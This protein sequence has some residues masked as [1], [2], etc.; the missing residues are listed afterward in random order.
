MPL[1][2]TGLL[3]M[4]CFC[5]NRLKPL[6]TL[7]IVRILA[8]DPFYTR[9]GA[10]LG[11]GKLFTSSPNRPAIKVYVKRTRGQMAR[12]FDSAGLIVDPSQVLISEATEKNAVAYTMRA[13]VEF[14][15]RP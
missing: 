14:V 6:T 10:N 3:I 4:D 8:T 5:R 9:Q 11:I 1:S 7:R 12:T 15:H 2:P 13:S